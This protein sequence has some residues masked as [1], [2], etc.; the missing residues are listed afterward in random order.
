MLRSFLILFSLL[1]TSL[2]ASEIQDSA[3]LAE[4]TENL[5]SQTADIASSSPSFGATFIK[6]VLTLVA[7]L[8]LLFFTFWILKK[9]SRSRYLQMHQTGP[10][11]LIESKAISPK[12]MLYLIELDGK[13][14][15]IAESQ[16]EV[17]R[18]FT[19]Q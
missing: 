4:L 10:M 18:L 9:I 11:K 3:L 19:S 16:A 5:P 8:I 2:S 7:I 14:I 12:T 1:F 15:M 6:M 17:R 13:R